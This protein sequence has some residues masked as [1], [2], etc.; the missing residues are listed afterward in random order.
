MNNTEY[1][2]TVDPPRPADL[3][4]KIGDLFAGTIFEGPR[5]GG[6][7]YMR[8]R[9]GTVLPPKGIGSKADY[10]PALYLSAADGHV[11]WWP[12]SDRPAKIFT[13]VNIELKS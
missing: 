8:L 9:N 13:K 12:I 3:L 5:P 11:S 10:A 6:H 1:K 7:I 2:I 4:P